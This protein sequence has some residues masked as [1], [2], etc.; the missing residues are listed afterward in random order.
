MWR[1]LHSLYMR[2]RGRRHWM[3]ATI[4]GSVDLGFL[5][6]VEALHTG[7]KLGK[8]AYV[9]RDACVIFYD[10]IPTTTMEKV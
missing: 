10:V 4:G 3:A 2:L 5:T 6:D 8:V 1:R 9:D 7:T